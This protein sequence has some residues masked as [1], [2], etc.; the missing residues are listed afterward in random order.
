MKILAGI[1]WARS[2]P[3]VVREARLWARRLEAEIILLHVAE[4]DPSTTGHGPG[5]ESIRLAIA[6]KFTRACQRLEALAVELRKEG[7]QATALVIQGRPAEVLLREAE[8]QHA[9][10]LLLAVHA[11]AEAPPQ[12]IGRTARQVA[13]LTTRPLILVPPLPP[14]A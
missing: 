8:N 6:H 13:A 4:P 7:F 12:Y 11:R 9:D 3:A 1:D 10:V 2:T 14:A 5:P